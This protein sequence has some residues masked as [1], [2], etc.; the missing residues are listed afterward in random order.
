MRPPSRYPLCAAD[1]FAAMADCQ[2]AC[3]LANQLR[4]YHARRKL[5]PFLNQSQGKRGSRWVN[6]TGVTLLNVRLGF[7]RVRQQ[8]GKEFCVLAEA[9]T[10]QITKRAMQ[11]WSFVRRNRVVLGPVDQECTGC[12]AEL[13]RR[14]VTLHSYRW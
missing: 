8:F 7:P 1:G 4:A 9:W 5:D 3:V 12:T 11:Q 13:V 6:L 14:T 10:A 2:Y